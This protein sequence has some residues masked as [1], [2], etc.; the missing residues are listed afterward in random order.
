MDNR[1]HKVVAN[2][3]QVAPLAISPQMQCFLNNLIEK[4][5]ARQKYAKKFNNIHC[6]DKRR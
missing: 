1:Q 2:G 5:K 4:E 6:R 3:W